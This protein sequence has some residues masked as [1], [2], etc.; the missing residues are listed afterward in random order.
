[1]SIADNNYISMKNSFHEQLLT[2]HSIRRYI[3]QAL[4]P[5][6]VRTILE[7]ALLAPSGKSIRPWQFVVVD[8]K[9]KLHALSLCRK[10][11]SQ[12]IAGAA[13]AVVVIADPGKSDVYIEDST[14]AAVF[15]QLQANALGLGSCWIQIRGRETPDGTSAGEYVQQQL[16]IP[17]YLKV[18]CIVTFGYKNEERRPVDPSKLLWEKVHIESWKDN[19]EE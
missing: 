6:D 12:P 1:M 7:A 8:D 14:I 2:R 11:G 4:N 17:E 3:E 15:M 10:F 19:G 13:M 16:G 9:D 5:D 18:E